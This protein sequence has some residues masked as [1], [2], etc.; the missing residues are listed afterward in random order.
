MIVSWLAPTLTL[1][2]GAKKEDVG[3]GS[4]KHDVCSLAADESVDAAESGQIIVAGISKQRVGD[5]I[6]ADG[7]VAVP[8]NPVFD[9]SMVV[10]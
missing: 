4:T 9:P 1:L 8:P 7:I 5:R 2:G 10:S 3:L 6:T